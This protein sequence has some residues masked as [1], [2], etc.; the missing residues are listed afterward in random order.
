MDL[1]MGTLF[2]GTRQ[3]LLSRRATL[4]SRTMDFLPVSKNLRCTQVHQYDVAPEPRV[5]HE[6]CLGVYLVLDGGI[7]S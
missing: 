1:A 6:D 3:Q 5:I 4:W 7:S 2:L